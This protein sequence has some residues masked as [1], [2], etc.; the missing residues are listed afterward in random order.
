VGTEFKVMQELLRGATDDELSD[1]LAISLS[2]VKKAWSSIYV[3]A[4][5]RLLD[6]ILDL[7]PREEQNGDRGRQK[8]QRLLACLREHPEE[9]RPYSRK[10]R[11]ESQMAVQG[12][13]FDIG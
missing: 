2:A 9:L 7:D 10:T 4:A 8:K 11:K 6:S 3:R 12:S 13:P 5:E 1:E